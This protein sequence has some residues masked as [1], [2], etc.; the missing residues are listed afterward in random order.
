MVAVFVAAKVTFLTRL[1]VSAYHKLQQTNVK[2]IASGYKS[3]PVHAKR[4]L[5]TG[6]KLPVFLSERVLNS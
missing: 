5:T 2:N 3:P 6:K 4:R 1:T